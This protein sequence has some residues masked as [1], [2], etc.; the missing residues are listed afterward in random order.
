MTSSLFIW[1]W[2][3][4]EISAIAELSPGL[5]LRRKEWRPTV[6]PPDSLPAETG[7]A[8]VNVRRLVRLV[9]VEVEAIRA[10]SEHRRHARILAETF[11]KD[12]MTVDGD[13]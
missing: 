7:A 10:G 8:R 13:I 9:T 1:G 5:I 4:A 6:L 12:A 11:S 2:A 3:G